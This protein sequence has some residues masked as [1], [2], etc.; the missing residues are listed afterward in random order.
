MNA[1]LGLARSMGVAQRFDDILALLQ[2]QLFD[3]GA[4]L[5]SPD[6]DQKGTQLLQ[7]SCV[8]EL[9]K[10]IDS[11]ED[12]LPELKTFIL[13]G[14]AQAA[15]IVHLARCICRRAEREIVALSENSEIRP[16]V[17]K[18]VNRASDL[19]FV[20]AR[21]INAEEGVG[22]VAWEKGLRAGDQE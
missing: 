16:E 10:L 4:E 22:D 20:L 18:Y 2:N 9:E 3:L 7:E 11:L 1:T 12:T 14:G 13:P 19:L 15:A 21:A 5:A 8:A 6:A 17:L